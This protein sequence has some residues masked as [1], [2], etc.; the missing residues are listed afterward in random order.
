[1]KEVNSKQSYI[2]M[3]FFPGFIAAFFMILTLFCSRQLNAQE[4]KD[5]V[6]IRPNSKTGLS[7]GG[8]NLDRYPELATLAANSKMKLA[9]LEGPG[10]ISHIH[11]TR[12]GLNSGEQERLFARGI[13]LEIWFDDAKEAAV[14]CPLAD[15]FGDGCNGESMDFSSNLIECAPGSYNCY[16]PMPFKEKAVVYLRNDTDFACSNYSF[17]EWK[18]LPKWNKDHGY[19]HATYNRKVFQLLKNTDETF[20]EI[21][22][23][24]QVLGRQLSVVTDDPAF[25]GFIYVME[26]NNEIDIDG[27][28][29]AFDYLGS[30]DSFGFSWGFGRTFAGQRAGITLVQH[31]N[32]ARLSLYRFHDHQPIRFNKSLKWHINWGCER[33]IHGDTKSAE[34]RYYWEVVHK[35]SRQAGNCWV[36][37]AI[38]HYWYQDRPGGFEHEPLRPVKE[39]TREILKANVT[40]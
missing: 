24:G 11:S 37:Y 31:Q 10:M 38:V 7:N 33:H 23:K 19:F 26:G 27:Q 25:N 3:L 28:E 32:P 13:V 34:G 29:R 1:M 12:H 21:T 6:L 2:S 35:K 14:M 39:R 5:Y 17:V 22:G 9:A 8:W 15:F 36:D 40:N 20:L 16:F 30:E 18:K 4:I